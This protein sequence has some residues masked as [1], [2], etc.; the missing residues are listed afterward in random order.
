MA[1]RDMNPEQAQKHLLLKRPHVHSTLPART[2]VKQYW[3]TLQDS[4]EQVSAED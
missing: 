4:D 3:S 1:H 2:V